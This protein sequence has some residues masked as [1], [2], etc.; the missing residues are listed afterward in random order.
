MNFCYQFVAYRNNVIQI[1]I[2]EKNKYIVESIK[3]LMMRICLKIKQV[4]CVCGLFVDPVLKPPSMARLNKHARVTTVASKHLKLLPPITWL[5]H[6]AAGQE[7]C[8]FHGSC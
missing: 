3:K 8:G 5:S 4:F 1:I 6:H 7:L 2:L